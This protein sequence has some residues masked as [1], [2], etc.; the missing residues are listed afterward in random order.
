MIGTQ[1]RWQEE[2][3]VAAPLRTLVPDDHILKQ[4]DTVVDLS[5]V[6]EEVRDCYCEDNGRPSIAPEA[7]LRLMVAGFFC[8]IV[9][10][11]K[12]MREAQVNIAI[13]WFAGYRLHEQ[14][15]DHSSLTRIRQRWGAECFQR[16]FVRV[17]RACADAGLVSGQTVHVDATLIRANVSWESLSAEHAATVW[18][19]NQQPEPEAEPE[20]ATPAGR[21]RRGPKRRRHTP[22]KRSRTDPD[23]SMATSRADRP[24]EPSYKQ[25]TAVDDASG[26]IL[27]AEVSTGEANEGA[28]LQ[29]QLQRI[30]AVTG[31]KVQTVTAD[32]AY[33]HGRN[34][35]A[36]EQ[37]GTEAV[38]PPQREPRR[39][40]RLP[41]R[42]FKYDGKHGVVR[43]PGGK[44]LR[45]GHTDA[46]GTWYRAAASDCAGC[47]LRAR[48]VPPSATSRTV[49]IVQG[50]EAL[51]RARRRWS[52]GEEHSR[53]LYSRHRWRVEGVHG[54]AKTQ[55]GLRR[56]VRWGR[57]NVAIQAY[58][59]ATAMN[60]KR[61]AAALS[62][63]RSARAMQQA[64][65]ARS[66]H[67]V[68][69]LGGALGWLRCHGCLQ[70]LRR[71]RPGSR[72]CGIT[73][74]SSGPA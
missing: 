69:A 9:H 30:E 71:P 60:L 13:R 40:R 10:D 20:E 39:A 61:L 66:R 70:W 55:H 68:R 72:A 62:P 21:R 63:G 11:R 5:W 48:C 31:T 52:R 23:A 58:L 24:L 47:P 25:H 36:L 50:Y 12:L 59:T 38:I 2:L 1:D 34:Y 65:A 32:T 22:K 49:L 19:E 37:R 35:E 54:E 27:D 42:R 64:L 4:V 45:R 28:Q 51:L 15:P 57:A 6:E 17:V 41:L 56:A 7:A 44:L 67:V 53:K 33:A 26:V 3:F 46:R 74:S 8:G 29:E 73:P 43:C 16:I 14:V 18:Q